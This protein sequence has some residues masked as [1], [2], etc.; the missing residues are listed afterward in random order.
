MR[1]RAGRAVRAAQPQLDFGGL[2]Q[3]AP[4]HSAHAASRAASSGSNLPLSPLSSFARHRV[5]SLVCQRFLRLVNSPQLLEVVGV[6]LPEASACLPLL[7]PLCRWLVKRVVGKV[8]RL[9]FMTGYFA[10][11]EEWAAGGG[12]ERALLASVLDACAADLSCRLEELELSGACLPPGI[13]PWMAPLHNLKRLIL[14]CGT[15][16]VL[17][18]SLASLT[19]LEE[20]ELRAFPVLLNSPRVQFPHHLTKLR[21]GPVVAGWVGM[22][23][24]H[25]LPL[26]VRRAPPARSLTALRSAKCC[27]NLP[28]YALPASQPACFVSRPAAGIVRVAEG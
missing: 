1:L 22:A 14:R 5:L 25:I 24:S 7:R 28:A 3:R 19:R 12:E 23:P 4:P 21:L 26:Q 8:R 9:R 27:H 11:E 16:Q 18:A 15:T 13:Y 2:A 6:N 20:L 17:N 10:S